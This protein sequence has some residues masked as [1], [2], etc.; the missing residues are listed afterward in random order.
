MFKPHFFVEI[1]FNYDVLVELNN[2]VEP[3]SEALP[4]SDQNITSEAPK[5]LLCSSIA[6]GSDLGSN[7]GVTAIGGNRKGIPRTQLVLSVSV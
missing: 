3:I 5:L 6:S 2:P 1:N 7:E 4:L